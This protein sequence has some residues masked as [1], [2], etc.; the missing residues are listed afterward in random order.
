MARYIA[1]RIEKG[2]LKY[3]EIVPKWKSYKAAIDAIL[4]ADGHEDLIEE[5]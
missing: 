3:S 5:I 4:T 1:K 2:A